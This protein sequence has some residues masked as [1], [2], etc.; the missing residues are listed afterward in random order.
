MSDPG[1]FGVLIVGVTNNLKFGYARNVLDFSK[2]VSGT[3]LVS[4]EY[5]VKVCV[6]RVGEHVA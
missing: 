1:L 5:L 3:F 6:H 2:R 4:V